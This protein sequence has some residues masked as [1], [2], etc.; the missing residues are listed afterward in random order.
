MFKC[1]RVCMCSSCSSNLP[2]KC[3]NCYS[4]VEKTCVFW[5]CLLS[6]G[7]AEMLAVFSLVIPF[8]RSPGRPR[9]RCLDSEIFERWR[10][11]W[12]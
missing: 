2:I 3:C 4:K 6:A 10:E 8:D 7:K 11:I 12:T 1:V 5:L 9:Q